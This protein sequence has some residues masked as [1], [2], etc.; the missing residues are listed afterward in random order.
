MKKQEN[1]QQVERGKAEQ[2]S[3]SAGQ[4]NQILQ[5]LHFEDPEMMNNFEFIEFE[6]NIINSDSEWYTTFII[7]DFVRNFESEIFLTANFYLG[8]SRSNLLRFLNL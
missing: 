5:N 4:I 1:L 3:Q 6:S 2:I 7:D 8:F